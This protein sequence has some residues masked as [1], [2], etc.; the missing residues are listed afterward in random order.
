M[1]IVYLGLFAKIFDWVFNAI[2]SPVTNFISKLLSKV[3]GWV[4]TNVLV[5]VLNF[6]IENFLEIWIIELKILFS[7]LLLRV[8]TAILVRIFELP[9][10]P[11]LLLPL[12][13]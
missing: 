12:L 5:P 2:L 13:S 3:L 8:T 11:S 9:V 4:F 10:L 1:Q 6:V 7:Q